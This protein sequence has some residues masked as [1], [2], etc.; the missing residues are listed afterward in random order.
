[1]LVGPLVPTIL[2]LAAPNVVKRLGAEP[3]VDRRRLVRGRLGNGRA[4]GAGAGLSRTDHPA[5]DVGRRHGRGVASSVARALARAI[6]ERPRTPP[7]TALA[8]AA[9]MTVLF[10]IVFVGFGRPL[11]GALGGSGAALE[12][13]VAFSTVMFLGCGAHWLANTLASILRGTGDMYSP[14]VALITMAIMQI[15]LSGALTLG[16]GWLPEPRSRGAGRCRGDLLRRRRPLD[17]AAVPGRPGR[18]GACIGRRT[19]STGRPSARR[20]PEGRP[21][22]SLRRGRADQRKRCWWSPALIGRA[23]RTP[24]ICWANGRRSSAWNIF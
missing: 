11:F 4:G 20:H 18:G 2:T 15:P 10:A 1:M 9:A 5:D 19:A 12:G 6:A 23:G 13:A 21:P 3:G 22:P 24:L 7:R 14:G 17:P 8:I 16:L